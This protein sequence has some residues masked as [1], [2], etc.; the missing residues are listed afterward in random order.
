MSSPTGASGWFLPSS[1]SGTSGTMIIFVCQPNYD[2]CELEGARFACLV[3]GSA[4]SRMARA[5]VKA[6]PSGG[7]RWYGL[8]VPEIIKRS[9][10]SENTV[11]DMANGEKPHNNSSWMA[12]SR[13]LGFLP[14]HLLK[15]L[16]G[17]ADADVPAESPI[18]RR[19]AQM[20]GELAAIGALREDVDLPKDVVYRIDKKIDII[21]S[22]QGSSDG[23]MEP[24]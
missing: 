5:V 16:N 12:M 7:L 15:I 22:T 3:P 11:R 24:D 13:A 20:V 6:V 9:G 10:L 21:I 23:T 1:N 19:L 18:E 8:S 2:Q 14:D 17:E 4:V